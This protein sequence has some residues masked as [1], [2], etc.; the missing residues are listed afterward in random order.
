MRRVCRRPVSLAS[1]GLAWFGPT[2]GG[3]T[4]ETCDIP[5]RVLH[6]PFHRRSRQV[7]AEKKR[8]QEGVKDVSVVY[9]PAQPFSPSSGRR[10]GR[11][12]RRVVVGSEPSAEG[13]VRR[14]GTGG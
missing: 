13:G 6:P 1:P 5:A 11:G 2:E 10:P 14:A 8:F 12:R 4:V 7:L 3:F 9:R